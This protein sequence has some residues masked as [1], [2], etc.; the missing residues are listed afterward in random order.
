MELLNKSSWGRTINVSPYVC[1]MLIYDP[2]DLSL[3]IDFVFLDE[4]LLVF[5]VL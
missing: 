1:T 4:P 2:I 5:Y 3:E